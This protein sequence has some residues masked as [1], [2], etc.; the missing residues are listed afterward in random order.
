MSI[1]F[2]K[3]QIDAPKSPSKMEIS[4]AVGKKKKAKA[5]IASVLELSLSDRHLQVIFTSSYVSTFLYIEA[6]GQKGQ[7]AK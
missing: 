2:N 6:K 3:S 5:G 7:R 1:V 4:C